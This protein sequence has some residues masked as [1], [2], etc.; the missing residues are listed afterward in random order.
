M[1]VVYH[2][3]F[4]LYHCVFRML[5]FL[6]RFDK[7]SY[8]EIDRLRIWDFYLLFPEKAHNI[9]LKRDEDEIRKLRNL[10]IS[11]SNNPYEI[12]ID[13]RKLFEKIKPYQITAIKC[14]A[15]HKIINKEFLKENRVN[16]VSKQVLDNY[17]SKFDPL[18]AK[19]QNIVTLMTNHFYNI[20][21]FGPDGFKSRTKLM[22]T[23]YD[24]Q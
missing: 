3:A 21:M 24:A 10:Y 6:T 20:P 22:E 7:T 2:Q 14:L 4:D 16:I 15:S 17:V 13:N 5:Q 12:V 9:T 19:E 11:K 1:R 23:K 8:L 18:S